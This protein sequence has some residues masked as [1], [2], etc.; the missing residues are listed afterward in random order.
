MVNIK[1]KFPEG[2]SNLAMQSNGPL[3]PS[4]LLA[5]TQKTPRGL[6]TTLQNVMQMSWQPPAGAKKK[7]YN[8]TLGAVVIVDHAMKR[9]IKTERIMTQVAEQL[10]IT[11]PNPMVGNV[12]LPNTGTTWPLLWAY[13]FR[14]FLDSNNHPRGV[15]SNN[16]GW[17]SQRVIQQFL[18]LSPLFLDG[19]MG[20][21]S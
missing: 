13:Y 10:G 17:V 15:W 4:C 19:S 6:W 9:P 21:H 18:R 14:H 16:C 12:R 11:L 2:M 3:P 20:L 7:K 5:D 1:I 8:S